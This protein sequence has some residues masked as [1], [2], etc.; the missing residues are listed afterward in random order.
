MSSKDLLRYLLETAPKGSLKDLSAIVDVPTTKDDK[1]GE[2]GLTDVYT[3]S[4]EIKGKVVVIK[5]LRIRDEDALHCKG[6]FVV[7][8]RI[9]LKKLKNKIF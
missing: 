4:A 1:I 2:G 7:R 8:V 6:P 3:T 9:T 5:L